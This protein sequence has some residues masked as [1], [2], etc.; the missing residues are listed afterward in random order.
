MHT[1]RARGWLGTSKRLACEV[2]LANIGPAGIL[3]PL[4]WLCERTGR[5]RVHATTRDET[6]S[7]QCTWVSNIC[8]DHLDSA[9]YAHRCGAEI[10]P[11]NGVVEV[12]CM[13]ARGS[14]AWPS[15][16]HAG[17][18]RNIQPSRDASLFTLLV[19]PLRRTIQPALSVAHAASPA[20]CS[21]IPSGMCCAHHK[22]LAR[23]LEAHHGY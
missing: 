4:N 6:H 20:N 23:L 17:A 13:R 18:T 5:H 21:A 1:Q 15:W 2:K 8:N 10:L 14:G 12:A 16:V 19:V 7:K 9:T 11:E 22:G 3:V